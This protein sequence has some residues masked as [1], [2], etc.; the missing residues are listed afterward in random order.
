MGWDG[1]A[2]L[3]PNAAADLDKA[4]LTHFGFETFLEGQRDVVEH[5]I[6]GRSAAAV[7]PTGGGKVALLSAAGGLARGRWS[8]G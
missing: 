8:S 3:D 4:L 5:L 2:T 1:H 6:A 7:F